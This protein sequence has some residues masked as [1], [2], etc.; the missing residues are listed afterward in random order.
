MLAS[1]IHALAQTPP[2]DNFDN[3]TVLS[4][5]SVTFGGSLAG[6]TLESAETNGESYFMTGG[7]TG[8]LWWTW[9]ASTSSTVVISLTGAQ[10]SYNRIGVYTGSSLDA[11]TLEGFDYFAKPIGRYLRFDVTAGTTYQIQVI[12][13]ETQ[14][15]S[16][17]LTATNP[18]LFIFQPQDCTVS[19]YGSAFFSALATGPRTFLV[20]PTTSYQWFFNGIAIP[21]QTF[22]S[23]LVHGV[24]SNQVGAYSVIASN[25]G[26][27]TQSG[28]ATL[29]LADT[30]PV[31]RITA[32]Q[33]VNPA[34]I[35]FSLTGEPG[36][37]YKI[38]SATDLLNW[39]NTLY[40]QLTNPITVVSLQRLA[41]AHFVRASLDVPT[42]VCVAQLKQMHWALAVFAIEQEQSESSSYSLFNIM[43]YVPLNSQGEIN[44][45]PEGGT[46]ASGGSI[47][48]A[49]TCTLS[50]RGHAIPDAP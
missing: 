21:G 14:P 4:G 33:P 23:L 35:S 26:G 44:Y 2:N 10:P 27:V 42:D 20:Q 9:T 24:T 40:L 32:L 8:S 6:A 3:R 31:P 11:L 39:T 18:P 46:Y 17:Q 43:P 7:A 1:A 30:N 49:P 25:I 50:S 15:F 34:Q 29:T 28:S 19:P 12:G 41:P 5:S 16:I 47:T 13:S 22:P 48:Y 37:W 38:E 45:C 36:R